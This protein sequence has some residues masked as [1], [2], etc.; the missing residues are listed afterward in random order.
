MR[1]LLPKDIKISSSARVD[2]RSLLEGMCKIHNGVFFRGSIG[3]GS[4]IN[5][6]SVLAAD[7][8]RFTSIAPRVRSVDGQHP[9]KAPFVS[10]SPCFFSNRN[11]Q[12]RAGSTFAKK[13]VFS[14][15]T[16]QIDKKRRI[17][18]AIGNDCWVGEEALLISG[19]T[20]GDGAIVLARAVVTKDV[21]D[22]AIVGGVPARIIG[23][24]YDEETIHFL[25]KTKWWNNDKAWFEQHWNLLNDIDALKSYY[26]QNNND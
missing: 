24:R 18:V 16:Y 13:E 26:S 3:M 10:T 1:K 14:G 7:I 8:G 2:K 20:I 19:V 23:Y 17:H 11:T 5:E 12:Y 15:K 6:Q 4:Y 21:P 25:Q 22:Y 9:F